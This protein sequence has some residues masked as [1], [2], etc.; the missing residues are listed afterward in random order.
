MSTFSQIG[1]LFAD[2]IG[3][4]FRRFEDKNAHFEK[5]NPNLFSL[6]FPVY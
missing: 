3:E 2:Q 5:K 6:F 4:L 1:E